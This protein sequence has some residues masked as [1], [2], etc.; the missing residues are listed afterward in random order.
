MS[1][2]KYP[3]VSVVIPMY[4]VERYIEEAIDSV[5]AQTYPHFEIIC[6]DDGGSD[7]SV[8]LV[9]QYQDSRIRIVTQKN[10]GL[11]G[12]RNT[13]INASTGQYIA[14]L[15]AD[16]VWTPEKL[17]RH[18]EHLNQ[19]PMVGISYA[20]SQFIDQ[21]GN[22][23]G[24]GQYPR[25]GTVSA[26]HVF[27][28]NPI[29]NGSAPVIRAELF[30][31][32]KVEVFEDKNVRNTYFDESL[33]QSEDIDFWLRVALDSHWM[34]EG[35]EGIYTFYRVNA[36]GLS[37]NLDKQFGFWQQSVSKHQRKHPAF[38]ARWYRLAC[39]YQLRYLARR[40]ISANN[41]RTAVSLMFKALTMSPQILAQEPSRTLMTSA[42]SILSYLLPVRIYE[43]IQQMAMTTLSKP[44]SSKALK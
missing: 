42:C 40:A 32:V 34:I 3:L 8:A 2:V 36:G 5:L 33:R 39:A 26:S 19:S 7:N 14:L 38:F 1:Q 27:C 23:L 10:R 6:V 35:I 43:G 17:E 44:L 11:A 13:G 16:D 29:G 28:R 20:G 24:I 25:L 30:D 22:D 21:D 31:D 4:N 15:D 12:A 9:Q 41:G 18:V 37:A